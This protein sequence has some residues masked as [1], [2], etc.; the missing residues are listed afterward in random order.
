[1]SELTNVDWFFYLVFGDE[2]GA[3]FFKMSKALSAHNISLIP[4]TKE[5]LLSMGKAKNKV[6]VIFCVDGFEKKNKYEKSN[7]A[8]LLKKMVLSKRVALYHVS[9]FSTQ[10]LK[11]IEN[12]KFYQYYS[13]PL[14]IDLCVDHMINCQQ[15][16]FSDE[17][18]WKWGRGTNKSHYEAL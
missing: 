13:L 18:E 2:R 7:L 6:P 9:S 1:M 15:D 8:Y 17:K 11:L 5:Q 3:N 12:H 14:K 16:L 10:K 4:I